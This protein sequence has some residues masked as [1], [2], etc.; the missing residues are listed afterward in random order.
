M[1]SYRAFVMN[2]LSLFIQKTKARR[3]RVIYHA[4]KSNFPKVMVGTPMGYGAALE[5]NQSLT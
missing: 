4:I 2:P 5:Q 3:V 1:A